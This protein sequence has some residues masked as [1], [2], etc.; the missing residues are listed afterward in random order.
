M[1]RPPLTPPKEGNSDALTTPPLEGVGRSH[2]HTEYRDRVVTKTDTLYRD[3]EI[4]IQLPPERYVPRFYK[5]GTIVGVL[6]VMWL[7]VRT[8]KNI[9]KGL[10]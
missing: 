7:I 3:R 6:S 8:V 9:R 10:L 1:G 5:Y 4:Q 2:Y